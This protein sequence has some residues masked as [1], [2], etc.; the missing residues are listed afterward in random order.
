M[1]YLVNSSGKLIASSKRLAIVIRA[2]RRE[3]D[4]LRFAAEAIPEPAADI[5][6]LSARLLILESRSRAILCASPSSFP[7][8]GSRC[9]ELRATAKEETHDHSPGKLGRDSAPTSLTMECSSG[10]LTTA[11]VCRG[12]S[13]RASSPFAVSA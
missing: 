3:P 13:R 9:G 1:M 12:A 5:E 8:D 7:N 11:R 4:E 6:R 10:G 2:T